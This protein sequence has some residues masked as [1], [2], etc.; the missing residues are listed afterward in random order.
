MTGQ[1]VPKLR[2]RFLEDM[3]IKGLQPKTQ[4]MYLRAM[5]DFTRFPGHAPDIATQEEL[6]AFQAQGA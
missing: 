6:R 5:R 2:Q 4:T 1:Y 3:R